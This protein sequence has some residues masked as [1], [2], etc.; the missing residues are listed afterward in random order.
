MYAI[1]IYN[2]EN[3]TTV[4]RI[5]FATKKEANKFVKENTEKRGYDWFSKTNRSLEYNKLY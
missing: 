5:E 2:H 1:E 4:K 3:K